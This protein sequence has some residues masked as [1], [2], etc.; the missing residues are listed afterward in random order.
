VNSL[1]QPGRNNWFKHNVRL[2]VHSSLKKIYSQYSPFSFTSVSRV[3]RC[4]TLPTTSARWQTS[5]L[6]VVFVRP[7][8]RLWLCAVRG[9]R[10]TATELFRLPPL[11]FGTVCH[12]TSRLHSHCLFSA[13]FRSVTEDPSLQ[14]QFSLTMLLCPWSDTR[15][16]GHVNRC[17][18]L[19][20]VWYAVCRD[21]KGDGFR[22]E[23]FLRQQ[24]EWKWFLR[25]VSCV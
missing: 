17:F 9:C 2:F 23:V 25:D 12:T 7:R 4:C 10:R 11:E 22:P 8:H 19:L 6:D 3:C 1:T 5:R 15:H 21:S 24:R 14:T 16:Y 20:S 18:Y 13:V